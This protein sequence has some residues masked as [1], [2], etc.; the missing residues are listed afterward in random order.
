MS[1]QNARALA[2]VI[3]LLSELLEASG[4]DGDRGALTAAFAEVLT[5][6]GDPMQHISLLDRLVDDFG[7]L[8][9]DFIPIG[10]SLEATLNADPA[11]LPSRNSSSVASNSSSSRRRRFGFGLHRENSKLDGESKV[12][13]IFRTLSKN[14][15]SNDHDLR[16]SLYARSRPIDVDPRLRGPIRPSSRDRRSPH[17]YSG[18][19]SREQASAST[20]DLIH[21]DNSSQEDLSSRLAN[22][23]S[24]VG[25]VRRKRRSS[26]SDLRPL[27]ALIETPSSPAGTPT[28]NTPSRAESSEGN[29]AGRPSPSPSRF[30]SP[31]RAMPAPVR[32]STP[33]RKENIDPNQ[34]QATLKRHNA[35]RTPVQE[36]S[37]REQ[38]RS[39]PTR[40][41]ELKERPALLNATEVRRPQRGNSPQKQQTLRLQSPQK[42]FPFRSPCLCQKVKLT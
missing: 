22:G 1:P 10:V 32:P 25:S 21:Q 41:M 16:G 31:D 15:G 37:K 12:S 19:V 9:D 5:E 8:F 7:S 23:N 17:P 29:K 26:L 11:K 34:E 33:S 18:P 6:E 3:R 4:N 38:A 27:S 28:N 42:V 20:E 36:N 24:R 35:I 40:G 39:I 30:G 13:S 14:K 2:A